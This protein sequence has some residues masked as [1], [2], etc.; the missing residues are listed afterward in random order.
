MPTRASTARRFFVF[1]LMAIVFVY[2]LAEVVRGVVLFL[3]YLWRW[4]GFSVPALLLAAVLGIPIAWES[5]KVENEMLETTE[6]E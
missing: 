4:T 2:S 3:E 6:K 1:Y 5:V